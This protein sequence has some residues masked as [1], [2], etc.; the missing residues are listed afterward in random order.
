MLRRSTAGTLRQRI[1]AAILRAKVGLTLHQPF[2]ELK[3]RFAARRHSA[4]LDRGTGLGPDL[5]DR[6]MKEIVGHAR[7]DFAP[8]DEDSEFHPAR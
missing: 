1:A 6:V 8:V 2:E 3:S 4:L 5:G 7:R